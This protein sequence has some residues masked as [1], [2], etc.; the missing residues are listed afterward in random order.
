MVSE[1][2]MESWDEFLK[3]IK[4]LVA[5]LG[6]DAMSWIQS[7]RQAQQLMRR[8]VLKAQLELARGYVQI[9]EGM[10]QQPEPPGRKAKKEKIKI[11]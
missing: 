10:L 5:D 7:N 11:K 1:N 3:G 8:Q 4:G 9:L 6:I 2:D